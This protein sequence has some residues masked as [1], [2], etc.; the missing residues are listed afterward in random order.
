MQYIAYYSS[1]LATSIQSL[2]TSWRLVVFQSAKRNILPMTTID[3]VSNR[4]IVPAGECDKWV[5]TINKAL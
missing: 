4:T 1:T 5:C 2:I 3:R